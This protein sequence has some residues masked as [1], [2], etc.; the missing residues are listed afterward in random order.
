MFSSRAFPRLARVLCGSRPFT[1]AAPQRVMTAKGWRVPG[2]LG[3]VAGGALLWAWQRPTQAADPVAD[4]LVCKLDDLAEGVPKQVQ[5]GD[6]KDNFIVV[7]KVGGQV[8]AVSGKCPHFG[9]PLATGYLDGYHLFCPWHS[10][11]FD[12]RSGEIYGAPTVNSL[13]TYRARVAPNGDVLVSIPE[14]L[15]S[16]VAQSRPS[17]RLVKPDGTDHRTFVVIGGG[18]AGHA[19]AETLRK[20]GFKGKI[21]VLSQESVVPYDRALLSKNVKSDAATFALRPADFYTEYGIDLKLGASVTAIDPAN[22][23]VKTA[24]GEEFVSGYTEI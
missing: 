6:N 18:G 1:V 4:V 8:Y 2:L 5:V 23:L 21:I 19:C 7:A 14:A 11:A 13:T 9:A 15:L 17:P 12:I 20:N 3:V 22:H 16:K 10:A 24:S